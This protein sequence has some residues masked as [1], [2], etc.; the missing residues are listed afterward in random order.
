MCLYVLIV[1]GA[2]TLIY[3][4]PSRVAAQSRLLHVKINIF[5]PLIKPV[6]EAESDLVEGHC[7]ISVSLLAEQTSSWRSWWCAWFYDLQQKPPVSPC[8]HEKQFFLYMRCHL[9]VVVH[10]DSD[11]FL[12]FTLTSTLFLHV[13]VWEDFQESSHSMQVRQTN[14]DQ[15]HSHHSLCH[16]LRLIRPR[17]QSLMYSSLQITSEEESHKHRLSKVKSETNLMCN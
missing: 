16:F 2:F 4:G 7:T 17:C 14:M 15:T 13:K 10:F 6:S 11:F 5:Q 3:M 8:L 9:E 1:Y 12:R